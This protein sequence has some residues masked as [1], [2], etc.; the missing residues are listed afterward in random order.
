MIEIRNYNNEIINM[1]TARQIFV[2][3]SSPVS[4]PVTL[5][6][7]NSGNT[8]VNDVGLYLI[9]TNILGEIDHFSNKTPDEFYQELISLGSQNEPFG[10][11][12]Y[13]DGGNQEIF[14]SESNGSNKQNK[15][16][17]KSELQ[18]GDFIQIQLKYFRAP[19]SNAEILYIGVEAE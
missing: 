7:Y 5:N 12:V 8:V 11:K 6:I 4:N 18:T 14:F 19:N 2:D 17:L 16:V 1:E 9:P 15:I 13:F 10:L 3:I